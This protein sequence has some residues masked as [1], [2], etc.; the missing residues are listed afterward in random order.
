MQCVAR[1]ISDRHLLR[2]FE[3]RGTYANRITHA[4]AG[5]VENVPWME[6]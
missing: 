6:A 4:Y 1:R 2:L 3:Y 5:E